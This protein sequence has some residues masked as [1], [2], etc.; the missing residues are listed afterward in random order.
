[1]YSALAG[2]VEPGESLEQCVVRETLEEVG[3]A[4]EAPAYVGSQPWPFPRSLM[5]AFRAEAPLGDVRL[6]DDELEEA[7]WFTKDELRT[8]KGF[9]VPPP[10]SLAHRLIRAFADE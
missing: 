4:V 6:D 8:P 2:F 3:L 9:F 10:I 5:L 1:M 7:R